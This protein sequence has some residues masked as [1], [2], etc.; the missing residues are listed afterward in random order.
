M[1]TDNRPPELV[2]GVDRIEG[3]LADLET[4]YAKGYRPVT[5][6]EMA[7]TSSKMSMV[8]NCWICGQLRCSCSI[9]TISSVSVSSSV[10]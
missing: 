7:P 1:Y 10:R 2:R 4:L 3:K 8:T 9:W 6:S 5:F